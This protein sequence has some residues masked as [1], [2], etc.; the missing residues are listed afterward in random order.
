MDVSRISYELRKHYSVLIISTIEP[1]EWAPDSSR[2]HPG[3]GRGKTPFRERS[4][5]IT[6]K[7]TFPSQFRVWKL[8]LYQEEVSIFGHF[9]CSW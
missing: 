3:L 2:I 7:A 1:L 5:I 9:W 6:F 4:Y 8:Y